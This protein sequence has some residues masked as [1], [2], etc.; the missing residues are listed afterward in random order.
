MLLV[1]TCIVSF[2]LDEYDL[3]DMIYNVQF[4]EYTNMKE[5]NMMRRIKNE[6]NF[7]IGFF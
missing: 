7:D 4:L 2:F 5:M 6:V 1:I 3:E